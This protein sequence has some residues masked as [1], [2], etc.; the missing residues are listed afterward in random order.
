MGTEQG[1]W[2]EERS[3]NNA[4]KAILRFSGLAIQQKK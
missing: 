3:E 2:K 4:K 1:K